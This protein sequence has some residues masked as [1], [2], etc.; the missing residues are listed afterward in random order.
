ML[1][2]KN[3]LEHKINTN[4][5]CLILIILYFFN[6]FIFILKEFAILISYIKKSLITN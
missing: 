4:W 3:F 6:I 5:H 1:Q 2:N